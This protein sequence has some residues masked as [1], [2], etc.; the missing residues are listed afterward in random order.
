MDY[1][2]EPQPPVVLPILGRKD[3]FPVH[4]VY[5]CAQNYAA[6]E[7]EMGSVPERQKPFGFFKPTDAL[8]VAPNE[9]SVTM[10]YPGASRNVHHELE[11]VI[12]LGKGGSH[13][14]PSEAEDCIIGYAVGL[15][16][17]CRDLQTEAKSKGRPWDAAKG[18]DHS[19]PISALRLREPGEAL[20]THAAMLLTVNGEIRQA[21]DIAEMTW[22]P[23][24]IVSWFSK[25]WEFKAGDLIFTG[26]PQG[27]GPVQSG[28][29]LQASIA[30]LASMQVIIG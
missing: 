12:A 14:T 23:G 10:P 20:L 16:M 15:D 28:D 5:C 8:L 4:R 19:A 11:L 1:F 2:I 17:T 6:H 29:S 26:T 7:V 21:G 13:L 18:F 3:V 27:V 30:G 9:G 24:E 25:I 22:T